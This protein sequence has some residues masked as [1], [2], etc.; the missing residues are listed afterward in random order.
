MDFLDLA[1]KRY[2]CRNFSE[3]KVEKEK[4]DKLLE[5]FRLAPT[6]CNN[7]PQRVKII[8]SIE[9][10]K[11]LKFCTPC[12]WNAPLQLLICFDKNVSAKRKDNNFDLGYMDAS[13]ATTSMMYEAT[14]IG[15]QSTWVE[16]FKIDKIKQYF[17]IP[18]NFEIFG[19]L[20]VGYPKSD[21]K[22]A[23]LHNTRNSVDNFVF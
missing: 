14:D 7:Q 18:E 19:L 15:L 4:I 9:D 23:I 13:I 5:A 22:P 2:S 11:N 3:K 1:K 6:A 16:L 8:T 17:D 21:D 10:K 12:G 20:F